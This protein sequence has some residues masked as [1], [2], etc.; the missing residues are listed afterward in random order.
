MASTLRELKP[1]CVSK[2]ARQKFNSLVSLYGGRNATLSPLT[3]ERCLAGGSGSDSVSSSDSTSNIFQRRGD[4]WEPP[5]AR[6]RSRQLLGRLRL[7]DYIAETERTRR[8][9][10]PHARREGRSDSDDEPPEV[11]RRGFESDIPPESWTAAATPEEIEA[12]KP[13]RHEAPLRRHNPFELPFLSVEDQDRFLNDEAMLRDVH[14]APFQHGRI[15]R[16]QCNATV[17]HKHD[18]PPEVTVNCDTKIDF[19]E[20][21]SQPYYT[22]PLPNPFDV[23]EPPQ[24]FEVLEPPLPQ[25]PS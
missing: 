25:S 16:F 2:S 15:D 24:H 21:P 23:L 7:R 1:Q 10:D 5:T 4:A 19:V 8:G 18:E 13:G 3:V 22:R 6:A 14:I 20:A 9:D 11:L 17:K 12:L